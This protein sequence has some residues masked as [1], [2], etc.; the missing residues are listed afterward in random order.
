MVSPQSSKLDSFT[1]RIVI[2]CPDAN[3]GRI[4][5]VN[6]G[7]TTNNGNPASQQF[8][9]TAIRKAL[10][11]SQQIFPLEFDNVILSDNIEAV[12]S[13]GSDH[14]EFSP[15]GSFIPPVHS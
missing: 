1:G 12:K 11:F 13:A 10:L 2:L 14:V 6:E 3:C 7:V 9:E 15:V 4:E 5:R 8:E